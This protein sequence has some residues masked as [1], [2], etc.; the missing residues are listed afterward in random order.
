M[1]RCNQ[2]MADSQR[3]WAIIVI[4]SKGTKIRNSTID[5]R[6]AKITY[7]STFVQFRLEQQEM[8]LP[9]TRWHRRPDYC[10]RFFSA[11]PL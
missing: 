5:E 10:L 9:E 4:G 11:G 6:W 7:E 8:D 2:E 3:R 1:C